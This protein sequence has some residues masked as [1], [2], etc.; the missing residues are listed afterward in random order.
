MAGVY[1]MGASVM[2]V[3]TFDQTKAMDDADVII[4]KCYAN[5]RAVDDECAVVFDITKLEEYVLPVQQVTV[6]QTNTQSAEPTAEP[7]AE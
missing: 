5:G 2:D 6:P 7:T 4:G 1:T 3:N